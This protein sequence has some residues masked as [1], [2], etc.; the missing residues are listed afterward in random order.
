M[1]DY[2]DTRTT[3]AGMGL[4]QATAASTV[5]GSTASIT[6]GSTTVTAQVVRGLTL[7]TGDVV[8]VNRQGS[9]WWVLHKLY[10]AAPA[11]VI[12]SVPDPEP[13]PVVRTGSLVCTPIETRSRR[14]GKWRTDTDDTLQGAYGGYGNSTGCAFYGT[15]PRSLAGA[16]VTGVILKVKRERAGGFAAVASTLRLVTERTRPSGAPTLTSS[17]TGP[18][19]AVGKSTTTFTVPTSWGQSMVDGTAGGL[20]LF[21]GSGSPYIRFSGRGSWA[22]AWTLLIR[23]RR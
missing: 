2:A 21:D 11:V 9:Q 8:L 4:I 17:T 23:W 1:A 22:A 12:D 5:T 3:T 10:A 14:D 19:L 6:V 13:A 16:T 20:A 7:A 18:S 15:K